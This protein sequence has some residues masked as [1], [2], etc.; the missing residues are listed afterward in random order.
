LYPAAVHRPRPPSRR[1]A[2][3]AR[4]LMVVSLALGSAAVTH[5]QPTDAEKA[6]AV[7]AF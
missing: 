3:L 5:A 2:S 1:F 4:V 7:K 6:A